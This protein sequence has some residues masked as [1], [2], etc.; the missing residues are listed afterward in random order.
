VDVIFSPRA[1]GSRSATLTALANA[2]TDPTGDTGATGPIGTTGD[3]GATGDTGPTGP[4]APK[5]KISKVTVSGPSKVKRGRKATYKV[6][7]TNS[8]NATAT[9]V[10]LKV[11]GRGVSVN[12]SVG[13]V[14][15][16]KTRTVSIKPDSRGDPGRF[17]F[18]RRVRR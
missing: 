5:A 10:R 14:A 15:A 9:G 1:E 17:G 16:G 3:T 11:S 12:T 18:S 2:T 6:R 13:T 8:G 7:V 4:V